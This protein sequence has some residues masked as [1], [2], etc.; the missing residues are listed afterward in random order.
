M[1][2]TLIALASSLAP[3]PV[4]SQ[5][6]LAR[7]FVNPPAS[8]KPHT[9]WHWMDGN[10]TKEGITADLEAMAKAG[11]GGA[12]MFTVA[13]GI[14]AGPVGYMSPEWRAMMTHAVKEADRVGLELC[15][16][17]CAGWS[18]SGGPWITPENAMQ[19]LAWS[20]ETVSGPAHFS[21]TLAIPKA[22][23]VVRAVDYHKDIAVFAFRTPA[24]GKGAQPP[25]FLGR[26]GVVRTDGLRP[27]DQPATSAPVP[28]E[29]LIDLTSKMDATGH[30]QWDVPAGNWTILRMGHTPT[31][32]DNHPAPPEGDGLE[33]DKLSREALDMHWAGMMAKVLADVGPLAGKV[34]NNALIDSYEV[35]SQNWTP[36][37]REE[38]RARR[39][40]DPLPY[41]PTI[42]G[43]TIGSP[44]TTE[45]FLW[46]FRRT[47][48]DL[49]ADNYFGYFGEL[50]HKAGLQFSTEPYGNGGF[51]TMQAGGRADIPMGEFWVSGGAMETTKLAASIGHT[52]GHQVVGAESFTADEQRGRYLVEPYS[53]KALGDF[54]FTQGI[55]RYIFHRYA[56]QPWMNLQPGM[57]M[58]PWGT[59]LERTITWWDEASAWLRYVA[60]CQFLLQQGRFVADAAYFVGE[61]APNDLPSRSQLQPAIPAGYDYD[62]IDATLLLGQAGVRNGRI[63]LPSGMEYRV[64]VLPD[65][66]LMTPR[67]A[68]KIRSLVLAG[69]TVVGP[70]PTRS[71]SL[72]DVPRGDAEVRAIAEEVWGGLDGET[73]KEHRFGQGRVVWGKP[74]EEVFAGLAVSPDYE[75]R[76]GRTAFIHRRVEGAE[77]YFVSNQRYLPADVECTF[78]V[79]GRVPELWDAA[80]GTMRDAPAYRVEGGRTTV[81][82]HFDPAGS[83]FV[84]FRRPATR[85]HL[86]S[87][88][89]VDP[90]RKVVAP[91]KIVITRARYETADGLGAD[92]TETVRRLVAE[93][94]VEI[95]A[96][97]GMFGDPAVNVVKRL[98]IDYT[99]DGKAMSQTVAENETLTLLRIAAPPAFPSSTLRTNARGEVELIP[100]AKGTLSTK[101]ST[102]ATRS[103]AVSDSPLRLAIG[104]AWHL[105]FPPKLGAPPQV[106]LSRLISWTDHPVSGVRYFSGTATY[107]K[108]VTV[109]SAFLAPGRVVWLDLGRVKNFAEVVLNGKSLGVLWKEPF[110]LDVTQALKPGANALEVRVTNLWPNRL[111]G[112]EQLP[113]DVEWAGNRLK[114]WPDWLVKG[115][116]RPKTGRIA[117]TTWHFYN[118]DSPLLE[119]GLLGPVTLRSARIVRLPK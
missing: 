29:G 8:A 3:T 91:P 57:T 42:A 60:R 90:D 59:H 110:R 78:R 51:D 112:D 27:L 26:T 58:G 102:G 5:D 103:V 107:T 24:G 82:L 95:P 12:Q 88:E 31:G 114:G 48:A 79:A 37:F 50:C 86:V 23:Q 80:T 40:Y 30:L 119:S 92:V 67:L 71:P 49:Y 53:I 77:V 93:G 38:F 22:P 68:R 96:T 35:G 33:V 104:G 108:Q 73:V 101:S 2:L 76:G 109:P 115:E 41:L 69:A 17:N 13:V 97:N 43:W 87:A 62:G 61:G 52:Y 56:H 83:T 15:I 66:P 36:K 75:A 89:F 47:I 7:G 25:Q 18:S 46:D 100:W 11:M 6:P 111:I 106:E 99:L 55:N 44:A 45:R 85:A 32:K 16:H 84:V 98:R 64:L 94:Q 74:L 4:L 10:V 39:G 70:K 118:K 34:L 81:P 113:P 65:S 9:W 117:F 116:P 54:V 19:V 63:I 72:A 14:P 105:A 28:L 21:K 20:E 1:L